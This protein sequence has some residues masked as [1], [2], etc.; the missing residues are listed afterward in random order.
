MPIHPSETVVTGRSGFLEMPLGKTS[1][2][3]YLMARDFTL[4][5]L[6]TS[7][8]GLGLLRLHESEFL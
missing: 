7:S 4:S 2:G 6:K 8:Y 3:L 5:V 1:P